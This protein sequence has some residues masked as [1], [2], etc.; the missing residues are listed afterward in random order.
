MIV[1][2]CT[3]SSIIATVA[4]NG[5]SPESVPIVLG[6]K[7]QYPNRYRIADANT[8]GTQALVA[9]ATHSPTA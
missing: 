6:K 4:A 5:T 2:I 7:V 8:D 9:V 3:I 1:P